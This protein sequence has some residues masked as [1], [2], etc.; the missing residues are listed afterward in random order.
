MAIINKNIVSSKNIQNFKVGSIKKGKDKKLYKV[1]L[2]KKGIKK[3][4][5]TSGWETRCYNYLQSRIKRNIKK[6]K[7]GK[8]K[9]AKQ[10]VAISYSQTKK[11]FPTCSMFNK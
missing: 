6:Y 5:K 8:F 3:W 4:E 10:A 9:S 1:T 2:S 11:K 7:Q